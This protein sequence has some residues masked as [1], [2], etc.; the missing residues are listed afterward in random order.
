MANTTT[1]PLEEKIKLV[2]K[3]LS[4]RLVRNR[5]ELAQSRGRPQHEIKILADA[6]DRLLTSKTALI[7]L[8][9]SKSSPEEIV[10]LL[11][12]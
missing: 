3:L 9:M 1:N 6:Q 11:L 2:Q 8:L 5:A 12:K 4:L 7:V 10:K